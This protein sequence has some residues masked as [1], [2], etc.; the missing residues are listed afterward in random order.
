ME[1]K[2]KCN[3]TRGGVNKRGFEE[4]G[5]GVM[6]SGW[7]RAGEGGRMGEREK[8]RNPINQ[9]N[10]CPPRSF[11][12]SNEIG[13]NRARTGWA[14]HS[15]ITLH[16]DRPLLILKDIHYPALSVGLDCFQRHP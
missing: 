9:V 3:S 10:P 14:T 15:L 6:D 12:V 5:E 8:K 1:E 11:V 13:G 16:H 2:G 7:R 4:R